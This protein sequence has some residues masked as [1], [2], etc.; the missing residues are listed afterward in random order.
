ML[1]E[2]ITSLLL[3]VAHAFWKLPLFWVAG[4]N[5]IEMGAGP[6]LLPP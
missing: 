3:A 5:Q 6:G 2:V 4:T 1:Y